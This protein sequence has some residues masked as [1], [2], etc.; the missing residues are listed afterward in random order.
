MNDMNNY[1]T[2]DIEQSTSIELD[3]ITVKNN[4]NKSNLDKLDGEYIKFMSLSQTN[5]SMEYIYTIRS[6]KKEDTVISKYITN[7]D[8]KDEK[9]KY[10]IN[11]M[12]SKGVKIDFIDN[13]ILKS[14]NLP[15]LIIKGENSYE[16]SMQYNGK[17]DENVNHIFNVTSRYIKSE[18]I[19]IHPEEPE[20]IP[21]RGDLIFKY[22]K[23]HETQNSGEFEWSKQIECNILDEKMESKSN[24]R[25]HG[26]YKENFNIFINTD[27]GYISLH[28]GGDLTIS[29]ND[30]IIKNIIGI[31]IS[32]SEGIEIQSFSIPNCLS[33]N[34]NS[35][36]IYEYRDI[37]KNQYNISGN[38][39]I[40][41]PSNID[42]EN[43]I[44]VD[45][46]Y[47]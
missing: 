29:V 24:R 31:R 26:D 25:N 47:K 44:V 6:D 33:Q 35:D 4:N 27:S 3:L 20:E 11:R 18:E 9:Y 34:L 13:R 46:I 7:I 36:K 14:T 30:E 1:L 2:R 42:K 45:F 41:K 28:T 38:V 23:K 43:T 32:L 37:Y 39:Y 8:F 16:V 12:D 21:L 19:I 22:T 10:S 15:P 5:K 40:S 17:Y